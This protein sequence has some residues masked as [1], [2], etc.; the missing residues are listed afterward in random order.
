MKADLNVRQLAGVSS[1]QPLSESEGYVLEVLPGRGRVLV[2]GTTSTGVFYGLQSL[3][4]L[5]ANSTDQRTLPPVCHSLSATGRA[6]IMT[7][8]TMKT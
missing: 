3:L 7:S 8:T 2:T 1:D 6:Y 4:S 5:L